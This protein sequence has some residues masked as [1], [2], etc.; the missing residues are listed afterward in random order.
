M[1]NFI[2]SNSCNI[3]FDVIDG[4]PKIQ[5]AN[6]IGLLIFS[7]VALVFELIA[8]TVLTR[9]KLARFGSMRKSLIILTSIEMWLNT[10]IF[11]H[12]VWEE[13]WSSVHE[14]LTEF[15]FASLLFSLLNTAICSRNW[16]VTLIALARCEAIT[17][18]MAHRVS[19]HIFCPKR[20]IAFI[21][22]LILCGFFLSTLRLMFRH[23][24]VCENLN[25]IVLN[26]AKNKSVL[27]SASE[28]IF[29]AYQS[30]IPI[31]TVTM[32]TLFMIITLLRHKMP[33]VK[34]HSGHVHSK[35]SQNDRIRKSDHG[36]IVSTNQAT[37]QPNQIRATH[38]IL[39]ITA[40]F[41]ICEAP[42]FFVVVLVNFIN[43]DI[44]R[45][46]TKLLRFL[47]ITDTYANFVIYLLTSRPFRMELVNLLYCNRLPLHSRRTGS[48]YY[49]QNNINQHR[50]SAPCV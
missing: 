36:K 39:L 6:S 16:A 50:H 15:L 34:R 48:N 38:F 41:V 3:T 32:A 7:S 43:T 35:D 49:G 45:M 20:Q 42:I 33:S 9:V 27:E 11:V 22:C 8:I 44:L 14:T 29:F 18:P 4:L 37:R 25:N 46:I 23:A 21:L 40:V 47:I 13:Y 26:A 12:K 10:S 30:A 5:N 24:I 31:I 28:T 1:H 19:T 2:Y 17:R